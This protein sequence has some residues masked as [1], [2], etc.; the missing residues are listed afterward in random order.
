MYILTSLIISCTSFLLSNRRSLPGPFIWEYFIL[1]L[2]PHHIHSPMNATCSGIS[3]S[4]VFPCPFIAPLDPS[5]LN[6]LFASF[7]LSL[8]NCLLMVYLSFLL[9]FSHFSYFYLSLISFFFFITP[10]LWSAARINSLRFHA[11]SH[12]FSATSQNSSMICD[13]IVVRELAGGGW[14]GDTEKERWRWRVNKR[15]EIEILYI[16]EENER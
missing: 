7:S 5:I 6:P 8:Q 3:S 9:F 16:L 15:G 10:F 12:F 14:E 1:T 11:T 13:G 2:S 4:I